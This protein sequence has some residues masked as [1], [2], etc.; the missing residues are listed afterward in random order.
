M[1]SIHTDHCPTY[2]S[3]MVRAVAV[4]QMRS[5]LRSADI[6]QYMKPHCRTEIGKRAF[7][8]VGPLT[9]FYCHSTV[10]LTQNVLGNI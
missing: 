9:I 7:S 6:A 10:S 5:G 4:N 1:H 2:S 8:Y 3:D